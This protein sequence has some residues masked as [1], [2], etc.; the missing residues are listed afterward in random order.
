MKYFIIILLLVFTSCKTLQKSECNYITDYYPIIYKA[1]LEFL[2]ENYEKAFELY[3]DAFKSCPPPKELTYGEIGN[4]AE[5]CAILG[6]NDLA[7][8]YMKMDILRGFEIKWMLQNENF[9]KVFASKQGKKLISDYDHLRE[10]A[11]S[12]FNLNLREEIQKMR[13]EDQKYRVGEFRG[14]VDMREAVDDY[15]TKRIIEIFNEFGYPN[16]SVVGNYSIDQS[17]LS[18]STMLLHTSDS[19][20]INYF[21]PKITEFVRNGTC[22]P[23]TLGSILDQYHIYKGRPQIYGTYGSGKNYGNIISDRKILDSNRISIGLQPLEMMEKR[24]SLFYSK[25]EN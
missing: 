7:I 18:I 21:V 9:N 19:I 22:R 25:S 2:S 23:G 13:I 12:S 14:N 6:K 3:Q 1:D 4:F 10:T 20:R 24:D 11:L 16:E 5:T 17:H 8:K 15:N